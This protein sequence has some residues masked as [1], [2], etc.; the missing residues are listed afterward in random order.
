MGMIIIPLT[1]SKKVT[2]RRALPRGPVQLPKGYVGVKGLAMMLG[3]AWEQEISKARHCPMWRVPLTFL[4]DRQSGLALGE[5]QGEARALPL[6]S[7]PTTGQRD[8]FPACFDNM[9]GGFQAWL[10]LGLD[11]GNLSLA[12]GGCSAYWGWGWVSLS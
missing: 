1:Q 5:S 10:S 2:A 3:W 4:Y 6:G 7:A 11:T 9:M 8:L 12:Q